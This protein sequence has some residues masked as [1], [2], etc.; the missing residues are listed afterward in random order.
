MDRFRIAIVDDEPVVCREVKRCLSKE[1]YAI[2]TFGDGESALRR[3]EDYCFDLVLCDLNLPGLNGLD[4]LKFV[5]KRHPQ[6]EVILITAYSSVDTAI[7]AIRSGA[8]HY[9]TKPIKFAELRVLVKRALDKVHLV[10]EKDALKQA[11]FSQKRPAEIIGNSKSM[12]EV[13]QLIDKVG[14][15]D[16]NVLI[17]GESGT[18]KE[19]VAQA[20]HQRSP[21]RDNPFVSFN[22]GG[23]SEELITNELFG[24][25]KGA[26]TGANEMKIGLLEAAN[27]GTIF[28]DEISEMPLTMQ[29][30]LLR[31]VEERFLLRVGGIKQIPVDVRLVAASNQDLKTLAKSGSFREDLFYRLNVVV[32][33]LPPLR[34]RPEDIPLL[35]RHFLAKYSRTFGKEVIRVSSEVLDILTHYPFPGNVR[36]LENI[37]E[38]AV[39][40]SDETEI[41]ADD[42]PSDLR[43]LS[44]STIDT[45]S[46]VSLDEKEKQYIQEV[47]AKTNYRKNLAADI[48]GLPRTSFWRKLKRYG[49]E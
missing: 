38:R 40:L 24:H 25:E 1:P 36:E 48:L 20:L 46:W 49:L 10:R 4:V 39:A 37:I 14:P 43:E 30:K 17:H 45:Q 15:L 33:N 35:I 8:F 34:T 21:R 5:R 23:F 41:C 27:K 13:F 29:V 6:S 9:V 7:D 2:E 44:I 18:G 12:L 32:I 22:C 16:C 47:L 3:M 28:L 31:F 26:Y 42:L 11:L 19:M